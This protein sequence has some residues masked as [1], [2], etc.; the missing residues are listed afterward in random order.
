MM[1]VNYVPIK[2]KSSGWKRYRGGKSR[3]FRFHIYSYLLFVVQQ[4]YVSLFKRFTSLVPGTYTKFVTLPA[5]S[6][7]KSSV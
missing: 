5:K 4:R 6:G 3:E 7:Q 2:M 1:T